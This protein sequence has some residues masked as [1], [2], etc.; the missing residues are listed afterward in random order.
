[1]PNDGF[2]WSRS[3]A[4]PVSPGAESPQKL[5]QYRSSEM[6]KKEIVKGHTLYAPPEPTLGMS[7]QGTHLF[8]ARYTITY[9]D[10]YEN[11]YASIFDYN[12][13]EN[14]W[15]S[16]VRQEKVETDLSDLLA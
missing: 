11:K 9:R 4:G 5:H 6:G 8:T 16:V 1:M 15:Y 10:V 7:I 2:Y 14:I 3:S 12:Y 13:N